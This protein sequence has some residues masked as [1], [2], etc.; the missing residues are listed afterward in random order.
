MDRRSYISKHCRYCQIYLLLWQD[1][2]IQF[3]RFCVFVWFFL[4]QLFSI[5]KC[6]QRVHPFMIKV[7]PLTGRPPQ[8]TSAHRTR[9]K[10]APSAGHVG[11]ATRAS[12]CRAS[13][14]PT[15]RLMWTSVPRSPAGMAPPVWTGWATS[16]VCVLLGS[17]VG[18]GT[19]LGILSQSSLLIENEGIL[20]STIVNVRCA[21]VYVCAH[22]KAQ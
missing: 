4:K 6:L 3:L 20:F 16:P 22:A 2:T 5:R 11:T 13:R 8:R 19:V 7:S 9:A 17:L 15:A 21:S 18:D 10:T 14:A 1:T 12:A